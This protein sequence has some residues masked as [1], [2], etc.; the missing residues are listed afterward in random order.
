VPAQ[1]VPAVTYDYAHEDRI[2]KPNTYFYSIFQGADFLAVWRASRER[3]LDS[4]PT[5]EPAHPPVPLIDR[6]LEFGPTAILIDVA[7][8]QAVALIPGAPLPSPLKDLLHKFET[9]KRLHREYDARF[10][11]V[12]RAQNRDLGLYI[13][14]A[15]VL[16]EGYRRTLDL[17]LANAFLKIADTLC[18]VAATLETHQM[19]RLREILL[20]EQRLVSAL[21][22]THLDNGEHQR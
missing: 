19:R 4:L 21:E 16:A 1:D 5:S 6:H 18:S 10:R 20:E 15:E 9:T 3:V 12:D 11:A 17:R 2:A 14:F 13:K 22:A 7:M 8:I